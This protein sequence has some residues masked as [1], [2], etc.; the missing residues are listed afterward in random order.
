VHRIRL[1]ATFD[2][3]PTVIYRILA[4]AGL[5]PPLIRAPNP[6]R[7]DKSARSGAGDAAGG[8]ASN[9]LARA[10]RK[11]GDRRPPRAAYPELPAVVTDYHG[12]GFD[13]CDAPSAQYMQAWLRSSPYRA[14]G[15]YIG[16]ADR[17]CEQ[18]NLSA[19]W[20]RN[21]AMAGWHFFPM[22]VGPQAA[23]GQLSRSQAA[24]EGTSAAK[25]AAVQAERLGFGPRTPIYYDMEA[26]P[27]GVRVAALRFLSAWTKELH[28]LDFVSG[29]YSSSGSG[30]T[31][32]AGQYGRHTYQMPDVI[33]DALWNGRANTADGTYR[34]GEWQHHQRLHQFSGNVVQTHGGDTIDI[35]QDYLNVALPAPG[36]TAQAT[37]AVTQA[38]GTVDVFYRG[39]DHRLWREVRWSGSKWLPPVNMHQTLS[40]APSAVCIGYNVVDIFYRGPGGYLWEVS[41]RSGKGWGKPVKLA[42]MGVIGS[43]PRAVAQPNGVID[44][45]WRGSADDHLWH[46]EYNP[47]RG[48]AG[49][50]NLGGSLASQP[51]PVTSTPGRTTVFWEG[52]NGQLFHVTRYL[53]GHWSQP[54]SLGMGPLG[55]S[56]HATAEPDGKIQVVWRGTAPHQV[57]GAV[58][59]PTGRWTGPRSLRARIVNTPW[60]VTIFGGVR[61]FWRGPHN[62]M[63][64]SL[65]RGGRWAGPVRLGIWRLQ[66]SPFAA[67]GTGAGPLEVFWKGKSDLL[68]WSEL[69]PDGNWTEPRSLGGR[70]P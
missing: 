35:D 20:I 43:A 40:S 24:S 58:R 34:R 63:L 22:Y 5:P 8:S 66:G 46:A 30:I 23:Y 44:V 28:R 16:G 49:P 6:S 69:T 65:R 45:F 62:R 4:S 42:M 59:S 60:P 2:A 9:A 38:N 14:V 67:I 13:S 54:I 33:Y 31:D 10:G 39:A 50:Q 21:Q 1:T 68:W 51:S 15:I 3:N 12:L 70:L 41:E 61:V 17:A 56:V 29:V 53:G 25:D 26:Y 27:P 55:G 18:L 52:T 36:G 32:L 48:W 57:W 47:G 37:S 11:V 7:L 19:T 64:M